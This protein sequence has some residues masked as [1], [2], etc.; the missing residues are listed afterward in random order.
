[1]DQ[2]LFTTIKTYLPTFCRILFAEYFNTENAYSLIA[3]AMRLGLD[4]HLE[5]TFLSRDAGLEEHVKQGVGRCIGDTDVM[6]RAKYV[7]W[8]PGQRMRD[9][10]RGHADGT[11]S[12]Y[13]DYVEYTNGLSH[14]GAYD[15]DLQDLREVP[16]VNVGTTP[17]A[18]SAFCVRL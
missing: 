18:D 10:L 7:R 14:G 1:M 6:R 15:Q 9:A 8:R 5:I 16:I 17:C 3:D 4:S 12:S 11:E 2:Q 13:F